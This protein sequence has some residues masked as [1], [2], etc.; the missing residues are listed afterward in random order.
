MIRHGQ[1]E[2]DILN[3]HEGRADFPLTEL[4]IKQANSLGKWL[5]ENEKIDHILCSTLKRARMTADIISKHSE[6]EV[7]HKEKLMEWNNGL[8]AGLGREEANEKFPLPEG[9]RLPHHKFAETE[10]TIEFRMRAE[11][12]L[13]ELI[14]KYPHDSRICIVTHGGMLNMIFRAMMK[15]PVAS[16]FSIGCGDTCVSKFRYSERGCHI[17]YANSQEH[18]K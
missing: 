16:K 7:E 2:A 14:E 13:W 11:E 8:L 5:K 6:V 3:V 4:G 15:L 1:S 10:S 17:Y 9:G 12:F 18:L